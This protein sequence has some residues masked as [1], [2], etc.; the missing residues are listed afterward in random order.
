MSSSALSAPIAPIMKYGSIDKAE[1]LDR[2]EKG[3][4]PTSI[5]KRGDSSTSKKRTGSVEF[6]APEIVEKFPLLRRLTI[7]EKED[8]YEE[9]PDLKGLHNVNSRIIALRQKRK[10]KRILYAAV[11]VL[12]FILTALFIYLVTIFIANHRSIT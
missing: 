3:L 1:A 2:E 7:E 6:S 5:L 4:A 9:R 8:L 11:A 12:G 10:Q